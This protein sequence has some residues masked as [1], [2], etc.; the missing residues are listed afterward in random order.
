MK[1]NQQT[2]HFAKSYKQERISPLR[3]LI[4]RYFPPPLQKGF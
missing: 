2:L 3:S 1:T 4:E